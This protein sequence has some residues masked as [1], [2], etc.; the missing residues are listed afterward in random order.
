MTAVIEK[1][2]IHSYWQLNKTNF[3]NQN[4]EHLKKTLF[5]NFYL[6]NSLDLNF[7][8]FYLPFLQVSVQ[9]FIDYFSMLS[10]KYMFIY[11]TV[12]WSSYLQ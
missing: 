7:N 8:T 12:V 10:N 1:R 9:K 4:N 5:F 3:I 11:L 6:I 2:Y